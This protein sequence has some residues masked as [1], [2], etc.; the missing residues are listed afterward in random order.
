MS[1]PETSKPSKLTVLDCTFRDGGYYNNWDFKPKLVRA[2]LDAVAAA[3][4]D[5]VEIAFRANPAGQF[6]GP[7]AYGTDEFLRKLPISKAIALCVMADAKDLIKSEQQQAGA[8]RRTFAAKSESPVSMVRIATHFDELSH[9]E[10]LVATLKELGYVVGLNLMQSTQQGDAAIALAS[11]QIESWKS[12]DVLYFADSLGDMVPA[13]VRKMVGLL[14]SSWTGPL[15]MH[16]HDNK[17]IALLNS[18]EAIDQGVT[19][20]DSTMLGMGRGAGNTKTE[21]LLIELAARGYAEYDPRALFQ[22]VLEDFGAL[23]KEYQWG[24][25][26]LYYLAAEYA[27]HPTYVQKMMGLNHVSAATI[28]GGIERLKAL[29]SLSYNARN[30]ETAIGGTAVDQQG[31]CDA[32]QVVR[33]RDVLLVAGGQGAQDHL[34]GI[35]DFIARKQDLFVINLNAESQ[36]NEAQISAFAACHPVRVVAEF[37]RLLTLRKPLITPL[38]AIPEKW[39]ERMQKNANVLDYG[40]KTGSQDF[41]F[42]KHG[43][44]LPAALVALYAIAFACA[45][46]AKRVYLAGFDGFPPGDERQAEMIKWLEQYAETPGAAQL[47]AVTPTTYPVVQSSVYNPKA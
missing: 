24:S 31:S 8:V 39:V 32:S 30:L 26:L 25:T 14:R 19:W 40:L 16:A 3:H 9:C 46:G 23:Q 43:A 13:G 7:Y 29:P 41:V 4:V 5:V 44:V 11:A 38:G 17:G 22:V 34:E 45:G 18:L 33:G 12:V 35:S 6:C 36:L 27:I 37:E 15:G 21:H 10:S 42:G 20:I 47:I 2:Y 28:I 1:T